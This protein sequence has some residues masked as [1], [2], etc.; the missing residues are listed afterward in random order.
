[1]KIATAI[2]CA[3]CL[4]ALSSECYRVLQSASYRP[5]RGYFKLYLSLYCVVLLF[6]QTAAV[7]AAELWQYG[8]YFDAGLFALLAVV[9]NVIPRKSPLKLTKRVWRMMAAEAVALGLL[10]VFVGVAWWVW[11]LPLFVLFAW[12]ICLPADMLINR[13]YLRLA[14]AKLSQSGAKVIAV[15]G[16]YGKTSVKDMLAVLLNGCVS[17]K[18]SCNTPLGIAAFVN[19]TN[20]DGARYVLLEFGARKRGDIAQLC[21]LYRPICGIVTGVCA[22][23]LSTFKSLQ[24]VI[25]AKRELV[26][27]LP[28]NGFC[29]LNANDGIAPSFAAVGKCKKYL[30][31]EE[32]QIRSTTDL[33]GTTL[34]V[35]VSQQ[36]YTVALPQIA[37]Y[38]ADT[39]AM[40]LQTALRLGQPLDDFFAN[41]VNVKQTPHR[42]QPI[43]A[44]GFCIL[45]DSYNG[46][47]TGVES[48]CKTLRRFRCPKAVVT[49]GLVEC[50]RLR[51]EMNVQCGKMLGEVCDFAVVLGKNA[52]YLA[53]GLSSVGCK[54]A[55]AKSL[56]EAVRKA[57]PSAAGGILLFQ[58][59]LPDVVN[60]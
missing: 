28:Q 31:D 27:A 9:C 12:A 58:N 29:V 7:V 1:M 17:P 35:N 18:G 41:A 60:I 42:L 49:Q 24:N 52:K 38:I 59:D 48:C 8:V 3:I 56:D 4:T 6:A 45:D 13:R 44:N 19:K 21:A 39:F 57:S 11:S 16:S 46:S 43:K 36:I 40:C 33:G 20:L 25:A 5:Q 22:Q 50:G 2:F 55:F 15:T 14:Q 23:H 37:D 51:R 30:S 54:F 53:E 34:T 47:V 26:E 32:L 10:C